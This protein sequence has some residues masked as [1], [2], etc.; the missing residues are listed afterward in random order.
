MSI[1]S[2]SNRGLSAWLALLALVLPLTLALALALGAGGCGTESKSSGGGGGEEGEG[3]SSGSI[4]VAGTWQDNFGSAPMVIS[5][6]LWGWDELVEF[7]SDANWAVTHAP[8]DAEWQPDTYSKQVWTAVVD[9]VF[10][11]CTVA[12]GL[13][14]AEAARDTDALADASS[15]DESGCGDFAWSKMTRAEE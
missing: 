15:P 2:W 6:E 7:D 4:E 3:E 12:S 9:D 14:T 11:Y 10:H 5:D 1:R 13:E 8:A